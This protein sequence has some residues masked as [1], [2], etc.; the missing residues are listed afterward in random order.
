MSL[1]FL[2]TSLSHTESIHPPD[3]SWQLHA[4]DPE[5]NALKN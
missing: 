4:S 1:P 5:I 2:Y 3:F